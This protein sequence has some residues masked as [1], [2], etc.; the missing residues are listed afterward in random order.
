MVATQCP[1]PNQLEAFLLGDLEESTADFVHEH[2]EACAKCQTEVNRLDG[3]EDR[4]LRDLRSLR[5][6][7]VSASALPPELEAALAG[8]RSLTGG[9]SPPRQPTTGR[10]QPREALHSEAR[11]GS[12]RLEQR[13]GSGGMGTVYRARHQRLDKPVALKV[14]ACQGGTDREAVLR[15]E[16]EMTAIGRLEHPHLVRAYDAGESE[17]GRHLF[18]AMELVKGLDAGELVSRMG[19]LA[20]PDACEILRQTALGLDSIHQQGLVHRDIKPSNVMLAHADDQEGH[21]QAVVKVLD[22]GLARFHDLKDELTLTG[23]VVGTLDYLSPEQAAE[24]HLVGPASDLYSLGCM[25]YKLLTG[26]VPFAE[27][28]TSHPLQ[29]LQAHREK[30]PQPLR[31]I[32][33]DAPRNWKP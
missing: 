18:L 7:N 21:P 4:F 5:L 26:R 27:D 29:K 9:A 8:A 25:A 1:K 12:Y 31:K 2:T 30:T 16:R 3:V 33:P 20:V 14:I 23:Q 15:F 28:S 6:P 11:F 24:A 17:D 32:R 13:L 22:L 19:P 10:V